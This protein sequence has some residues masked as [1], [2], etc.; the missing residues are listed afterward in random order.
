[1][2]NVQ[3]DEQET[4]IPTEPEVDRCIYLISY[5]RIGLW[6]FKVFVYESAASRT[7]ELVRLVLFLRR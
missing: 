1:M 6:Q 5:F 4:Q 3:Y 7:D 2:S